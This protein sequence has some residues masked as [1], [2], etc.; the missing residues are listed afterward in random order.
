MQ[1]QPASGVFMQL[2]TP[3]GVF[4]QLQ[5]ASAESYKKKR[6]TER[7]VGG[8]VTAVGETSPQNS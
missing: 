7:V 6:Q 1:L 8:V 3:S 4:M 5:T 2:Q